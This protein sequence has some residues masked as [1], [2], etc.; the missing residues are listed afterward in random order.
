MLSPMS[1]LV[2]D[3]YADTRDMLSFALEAA[4]YGVLVAESGRQALMLAQLHHPAI[5]V[6]DVYMPEMDGIETTRRLRAEPDLQR[7]PRRRAH[8]ASPGTRRI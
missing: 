8:R 1:V 3:D 4:G 6:M 5:V 7:H 2:V